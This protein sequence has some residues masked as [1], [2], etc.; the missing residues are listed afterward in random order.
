MMLSVQETPQGPHYTQWNSITVHAKSI[1]LEIV[2]GRER[3]KDGGRMGGGGVENKTNS[4]GTGERESKS[5]D[6]GRRLLLP[7]ALWIYVCMSEQERNLVDEREIETFDRVISGGTRGL[8]ELL[9]EFEIKLSW[10]W[11]CFWLRSSTHTLVCAPN[12]HSCYF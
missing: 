11:F 3:A 12:A 5:E 8:S 4:R 6:E 7:P 9:V 1:I 10:C 2:G